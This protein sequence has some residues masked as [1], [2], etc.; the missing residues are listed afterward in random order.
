MNQPDPNQEVL[1]DQAAERL[2]N[3]LIDQYEWEQREKRKKAA[4]EAKK[5]EK[6]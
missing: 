1:L 6:E 3:I 2:A 5:S 4:E